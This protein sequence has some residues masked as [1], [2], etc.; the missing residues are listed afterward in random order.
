M[1]RSA[2]LYTEEEISASTTPGTLR[3]INEAGGIEAAC[4]PPTPTERE[5]ARWLKDQYAARGGAPPKG[6]DGVPSKEVY[7]EGSDLRKTGGPE[8]GERPERWGAPVVR[9]LLE[10][11]GGVDAVLEIPTEA[12]LQYWNWLQEQPRRSQR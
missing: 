10:E 4:E 2:R 3:L 9:S 6:P 7:A 1:N 12:E 11:M 8:V 5:Y